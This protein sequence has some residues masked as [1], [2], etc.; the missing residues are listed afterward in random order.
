MW[1]IRPRNTAKYVGVGFVW[2][3]IRHLRYVHLVL[4]KDEDIQHHLIEHLCNN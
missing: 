2:F 4:Y 3:L 1:R